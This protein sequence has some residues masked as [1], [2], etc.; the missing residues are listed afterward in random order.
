MAI[1]EVAGWSSHLNRKLKGTI[2]TKRRDLEKRYA[3][4]AQLRT[5]KVDEIRGQLGILPDPDDEEAVKFI[6]RWR[7]TG[8]APV[9]AQLKTKTQR[10]LREWHSIHMACIGIKDELEQLGNRRRI[11]GAEPSLSIAGR[12]R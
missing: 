11:T 4:A 7:E 2:V 6:A 5:K 1:T 8:K 12:R 9:P 3:A 10:L